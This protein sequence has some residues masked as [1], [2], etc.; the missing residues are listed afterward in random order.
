M[1]G[2]GGGPGLA[3]PWVWS[4]K[5][6]T[7][8]RVQAQCTVWS[9]PPQY[10]HR[11]GTVGPVRVRGGSSRAVHSGRVLVVCAYGITHTL[12]SWVRAA[13][14]GNIT[15]WGTSSAR[16]LL[17]PPIGTGACGAG[18]RGAYG[19]AWPGSRS[20]CDGV[21]QAG[22]TRPACSVYRHLGRSVSKCRCMASVVVASGRTTGRALGLCARWTGSV[23]VLA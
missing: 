17:V 3:L 12:A 21:L 11:Y 10:M 7:W 8:G 15:G 23:C 16:L 13:C 9:G 19:R 1:L 14:R 2:C 18:A 4:I 6:E 22:G 20:S 5:S